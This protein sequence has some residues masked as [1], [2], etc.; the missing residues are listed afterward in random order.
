MRKL[1]LDEPGYAFPMQLWP[2]VWGHKLRL[3][4]IPVRLI[5]NDPTRS[6]GALLD[7][8]AVRL[9]HYM[10]VLAREMSR[11]SEQTACPPVDRAA[12]CGCTE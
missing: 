11:L 5:Y 9:R 2:Q 7:D 6:F 1:V 3:T 12:L 4:E 8:A 10:D